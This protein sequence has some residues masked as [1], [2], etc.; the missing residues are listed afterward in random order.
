MKSQSFLLMAA[1][2]GSVS[3]QYFKH[4]VNS[5]YLKAS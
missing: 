1:M 4:I 2:K 3:A 5:P